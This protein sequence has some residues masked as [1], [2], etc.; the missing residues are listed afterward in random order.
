MLNL[1]LCQCNCFQ[2][3][4]GVYDFP[5]L[6]SSAALEWLGRLLASKNL[7]SP[8]GV[9][10]LEY[11]VLDHTLA[12]ALVPVT[13]EVS[14]SIAVPVSWVE[15]PVRGALSSLLETLM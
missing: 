2:S 6:A 4:G 11:L 3:P 12:G 7:V 10:A 15:M 8:P 5:P 13:D 9:L 14:T 1:L